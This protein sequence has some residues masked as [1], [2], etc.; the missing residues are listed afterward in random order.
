M[1]VTVNVTLHRRAIDTPV[2]QP[3]D[4]HLRGWQSSNLAST[5]IAPTVKTVSSTTVSAGKASIDRSVSDL[6]FALLAFE[7]T[8]HQY[9]H[10]A[11][12]V[13]IN[14]VKAITTSHSRPTIPPSRRTRNTRNSSTKPIPYPT[15]WATDRRAYKSALQHFYNRTEEYR[16]TPQ[17]RSYLPRPDRD[18]VNESSESSLYST[19][20]PPATAKSSKPP[21]MTESGKSEKHLSQQQPQQSEQ[22]IRPPSSVQVKKIETPMINGRL[23]L[24]D[25]NFVTSHESSFNKSKRMTTGKESSTTSFTKKSRHRSDRTEDPLKIIMKQMSL[26]SNRAFNYSKTQYAKNSAVVMT[27]IKNSQQAESSPYWNYIESHD[28]E[29]AIATYR[30]LSDIKK[31]FYR[32]EVIKILKAA[33]CPL[34]EKENFRNFMKRFRGGLTIGDNDLLESMSIRDVSKAPVHSLHFAPP[35]DLPAPPHRGIGILITSDPIREHF[36]IECQPSYHGNLFASVG[37]TSRPPVSAF[38]DRIQRETRPI[39]AEYR[40]P[41]TKHQ[42]RSPVRVLSPR[43]RSPSSPSLR[44]ILIPLSPRRPR[45]KNATT[46]Y[47]QQPTYERRHYDDM[48]PLP[49]DDRP[50]PRDDRPPPRDDRHV[51]E[52]YQQRP[53][54]PGYR[55]YPRDDRMNF[56]LRENRRLESLFNRPQ[57]SHVSRNRSHFSE[58]GRNS[59][60]DHDRYNA[61]RYE[62]RGYDRPHTRN[63]DRG[64]DRPYTRNDDRIIERVDQPRERPLRSQD[65]MIW[66]SSEHS[67]RFFIRRFQ[68]IA[69]IEET[70]A[71]LR[72]LSMCLK[73]DA[74]EWHNGLSTLMRSEMNESLAIW[75]DELLRKFRPN[76]FESLKKAEKMI[77]RFDDKK[78]SL[79]QYLTRK[80]N[81]LHDAEVSDKNIIM[82]HL[83]DGLKAQLTFVTSLREDEDITEAF[84]RRVRNN[85]QAARRI[86]KLQKRMTRSDQSTFLTNNNR[87]LTQSNRNTAPFVLSIARVDRLINNYQRTINK[88]TIPAIIAKPVQPLSA[89]SVAAAQSR[90]SLTPMKNNKL[91]RE[92]KR[93]CRH[94]GKNHWDYEHQW[95]NQNAMI[96]EADENDRSLILNLNK[97][98]IKTL[99]ALQK[100]KEQKKVKKKRWPMIVP[101]I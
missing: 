9:S 3:P 10:E 28:I 49:R 35:R 77:F 21:R 55:P 76:R 86:W 84:D 31:T 18:P 91:S 60:K 34:K 27:M 92:R 100:L 36:N 56:V 70:R 32:D 25:E 53:T 51:S 12:D 1:Q 69:E 29:V 44:R 5:A 97:K 58:L 80:T 16:S 11:S 46:Y 47:E 78:Q 23:H 8:G 64:Y 54:L 50:P 99:K 39:P 6:A 38:D 81:L 22:Q 83:W 79:N 66:D 87:G 13:M 2:S 14:T 33:G 17:Y 7:G 57:L 43:P 88:P 67:V 74:F 85:E 45:N 59:L 41:E 98:N 73:G 63:D 19:G 61:P 75:K 90:K 40:E 62:D 95:N 37:R 26:S 48:P 72:A 93:P 30:M 101:S 65:I 71:V 20:E 15:A 89:R 94:C 52:M 82:R 42:E 24:A 96:I 68:Q 4:P